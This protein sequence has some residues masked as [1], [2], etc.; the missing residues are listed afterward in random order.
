MSR[1]HRVTMA[2]LTGLPRLG[3]PARPVPAPHRGRARAAPLGRRARGLRRRHA[4]RSLGDL[5]HAVAPARPRGESVPV[6]AGRAL[7]AAP[8]SRPQLSRCA[9]AA[10]AMSATPPW[11]IPPSPG[12]PPTS[13]SRRA[14]ASSRT[15]STA[16][17]RPAQRRS[18]FWVIPFLRTN[19]WPVL[20]ARGGGGRAR[21]LV[22]EPPRPQRRRVMKAYVLIETAAGKTK[23]VKKTLTK[24]KSAKAT[25]VAMDAVT[26]PYDFI[27][28]VDGAS[29]DAIGNLVTES[30]GDHRRRDAHHHLRRR[31]HRLTGGGAARCARIPRHAG[32]RARRDG[33]HQPAP[34]AV[35]A[36]A[37]PR[38]HRLQPG[39]A[40]RAPA[41]RRARD[42]GRPEGPRR[43]ARARRRARPT[44][45]WSTSPTRPTLGE[46]VEALLR[47]L[48][49]RPHVL[50]VS[51]CRVYDHALPIPYSE[52]TPRSVY[53][54]DYARH[55]IAGEDALLERHRREGWPVTIVRPT[56]VMGP[57]N[58]RNNE[59]FFMDRIARGPPR[60]R[61]RRRRLA[62]T[63]RPRRRTSARRWPPCSAIP[64]PMARPTTSWARTW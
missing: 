52:T 36:A 63:V 15:S 7:L 11:P 34:R 39:P 6:P 51:T 47:A 9:T 21:R 16:P 28:V 54:G 50:F 64:A 18:P 45:R 62:A 12:R 13:C 57:L 61:P 35:A 60:A 20:G 46:D 48:R 37:W 17:P 29:L 8:A 3:V 38:G 26:G 56:H 4:R 14:C 40:S 19:F 5:L 42:R 31:R 23:N 59:T 24:V 43:V 30:I 25:V 1:R 58:T 53:W 33:V 32:A 41:R 44:T 49:G 22:G 10:R 2:S 55:K 27:A